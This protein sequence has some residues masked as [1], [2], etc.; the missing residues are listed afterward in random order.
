VTYKNNINA[1]TAKVIITDKPGGNYVVN[2]EATFTI[3]KRAA[4][5]TA[6]DQTV[7]VGEGITTGVEKVK[8]TGQVKGHTLKSV[9][10]S[11]SSTSQPTTSGKITP[12]AAKIVD[13]KGNDVT[14]NYKIK[15]TKGTLTVTENRKPV[16]PD[17]TLLAEMRTCGHKALRVIWTKV[18]DADGYD[19]Y[20]ARN[21]KK[22]KKSEVMSVTSTQTYKFSG[23]KK[24][25]EYKAY[26]QAWKW[27]NGKKSIIGRASPV[28]SAL[29]GN[30]NKEWTNPAS[31]KIKATELSLKVGKK[32]TIKA[33]VK[34]AKHDRKV[35]KQDCKLLRYYSSNRNV[36]SVSGS[37]T[38]KAV[39]KGTCTIWVIAANGKRV[40]VKVKVK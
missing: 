20:F 27:E 12:S 4:T 23:L 16:I 7:R 6:A 40:G 18:E 11:S 25:T 36:A 1:G 31:V 15:Y 17:Y 10:L 26:V 37:G 38:V 28:V 30:N 32:A 39:G 34:G 21:D 35:L 33:D 24:N 2:G 5:I 29:T 14:K 3:E 19:V 9:K 8:L 13:A 22:F